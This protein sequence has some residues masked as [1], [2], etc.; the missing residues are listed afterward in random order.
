[1]YN[2]IVMEH[3]GDHKM[4]DDVFRLCQ[5]VLSFMHLFI[6]STF[7]DITN[8]SSHFDIAYDLE[9]FSIIEESTVSVKDTLMSQ[10]CATTS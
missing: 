6:L 8:A 5:T 10:N 2:L 7:I 1:M 9:Q 4:L 3:L